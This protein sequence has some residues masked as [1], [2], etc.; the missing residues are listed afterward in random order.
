MNL[1][2]ID[3]PI[4][5]PNRAPLLKKMAVLGCGTIGASWVEAFLAHGLQVNVWD[6][7][8]RGQLIVNVPHDCAATSLSFVDT[9]AEAV[10]DAQF[11]QENGPE[12]LDVKRKLYSDIASTLQH[13]A[14]VASST[15]TLLASDL[16]AGNSFASRILVGHPFNPPHVIPLVEVV[17]G[18]ETSESAVLAAMC[19]YRQIHK[20]PIRLRRERPG[21]LANRLQAALW[22]EAVDAV[23]EGQASVA[24]VDAAMRLALG[25]RWAIMGPFATFN[26]A[27]GRAGLA[28]FFEH[29]GPAFEN[30]WDDAHRP[31]MTDALKEELIKG[32]GNDLLPESFETQL[33]RRDATLRNILAATGVHL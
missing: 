12:D 23:A 26:L 14:I 4:D 32:L 16:Q 1:N 18:R 31:Q 19:F 22:R 24:D 28:R 13:D 20:Y 11:I 33:V 15:S 27:G 21:H 7:R 30:L 6:P 2:D 25:P 8:P 5:A 9:P 29:L 10:T 17:G 3:W